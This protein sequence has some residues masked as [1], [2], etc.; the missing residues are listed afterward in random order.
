VSAIGEEV[1]KRI[2]EVREANDVIWLFDK[3]DTVVGF[4][5]SLGKRVRSTENWHAV[6]FWSLLSIMLWADHTQ[7]EA[8]VEELD[9]SPA[10]NATGAVSTYH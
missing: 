3:L 1:R 2:F 9:G 8:E 10:E 6:L 4:Y 7:L 5:L